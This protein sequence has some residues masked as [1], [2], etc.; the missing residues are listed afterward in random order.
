MDPIEKIAGTAF[1]QCRSEGFR[2]LKLWALMLAYENG[3]EKCH[4]LYE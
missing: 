1:C 3:V 2:N 4:N